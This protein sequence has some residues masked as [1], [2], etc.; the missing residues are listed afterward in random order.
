M[1]LRLHFNDHAGPI[2]AS[3][4]AQ[5]Y[6]AGVWAT[7]GLMCV[8]ALCGAFTDLAFNLEG[9]AWQLVNCLFT[10][11][12]SLYLRGVMDKV[13]TMTVSK[14]KLSEMSMVYYNNALS[15][16]FLLGLIY[17]SGE[18]ERLLD[19]PALRNPAFQAAACVTALVGFGIS[20]ASLW[21]LSSS[22]A[23][24]YSLVG[25]LN[26]IPIAIFGLLAFDT[27]WSLE[28]VGS[29]LVGLVAGAVFGLA[30]SK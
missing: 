6:G 5:V 18:S 12:Y 17:W 29:V 16:P 26:K 28:N 30:R 15:L 2:R 1:H 25:S 10:A 27:A 7:L 3:L 14:T 20:F 22:T 9:Y 24:T 13:T 19:Q 8:S 23:T 21:F 4:V 11:S